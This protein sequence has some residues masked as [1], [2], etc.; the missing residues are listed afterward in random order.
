MNDYLYRCTKCLILQ[1]KVNFHKKK[2]AK[3]GIR[4]VCKN[5]R[6][7]DRAN[8]YVDNK[9]KELAYN[10]DYKKNNPEKRK[11][12]SRESAA[13]NLA[14]FRLFL[15]KTKDVPCFDCGVKYPPCAMDFDHINPSLKKFN[16]SEAQCVRNE[17]L[18]QEI[19][20]CDIVC[21]NCH[22]IREHDRNHNKIS[23]WNQLIVY[24][25]KNVSCVDCHVNY[26][27]YVMDFDHRNPEEKLFHISKPMSHNKEEIIA[28]IKKCD[29]VCAN[30][31]RIRTFIKRENV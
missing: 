19:E 5:C 7:I 30:C 18:L 16:I 13:K 3:N 11:K 17:I 31:H 23:Y 27:P 26:P 9:E 28:E 20:K 4:S 8:K 25:Y 14:S 24:E 15:N 29:V 6:S 2:N 12:T 21:A 10:R 1:P 22:R